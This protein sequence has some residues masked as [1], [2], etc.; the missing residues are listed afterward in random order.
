MQAYSASTIMVYQVVRSAHLVHL[1]RQCFDNFFFSLFC[2]SLCEFTNMESPD[3]ADPQLNFPIAGGGEGAKQYFLLLLA[4]IEQQSARIKA[5]EDR[6]KQAE[7]NE[8]RAIGYKES[9][10]K[11]CDKLFAAWR[12]R[13]RAANECKQAI[14]AR[15]STQALE[16]RAQEERAQNVD[17]LNAA[18]Q[19]RNMSEQRT[20]ELEQEL[21]NQRILWIERACSEE[22]CAGKCDQAI[23]ARASAQTAEQRAQAQEERAQTAEK[24]AQTQEQ[25]A[26]TAEQLRDM[27]EHRT[28]EL[29]QELKKQRIFFERACR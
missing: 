29:E 6:M 24:L 27:F 8:K 23:A 13:A 12:V 16:Q 18:E 5:A 11:F 28:K 25:R 26:Q 17:A 21:K 19:L 15:A 3:I 14:E 2:C 22:R 1:V 7:E 4:M 9:C 20:K 10:D